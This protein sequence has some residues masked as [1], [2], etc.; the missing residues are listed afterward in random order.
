MAKRRCKFIPT[1]YINGSQA[2]PKCHWQNTTHFQPESKASSPIFLNSFLYF[3]I[4]KN[5]KIK[6]FADLQ[7][8]EDAYL[9]HLSPKTKNIKKNS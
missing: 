7:D 2:H 6:L 3:A 1:H 9:A 4:R 5:L 8:T